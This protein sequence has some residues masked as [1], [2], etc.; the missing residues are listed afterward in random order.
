MFRSGVRYHALHV[1]PPEEEHDC[2][3]FRAVA[4]IDKSQVLGLTV[5]LT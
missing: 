5:E 2:G 1:T 3:S 4:S